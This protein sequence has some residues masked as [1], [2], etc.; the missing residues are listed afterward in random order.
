[1]KRWHGCR[2]HHPVHRNSP[3]KTYLFGRFFAI[4][5]GGSCLPA[6]RS[7]LLGT[8]W[9]VCLRGKNPVRGGSLAGGGTERGY[10]TI[11]LAGLPKGENSCDERP[12][13]SPLIYLVSTGGSRLRHP[14]ESRWLEESQHLLWRG[15]AAFGRNIISVAERLHVRRSVEWVGRG[16]NVQQNALLNMDFQARSRCRCALGR[17]AVAIRTIC[18]EQM[19]ALERSFPRGDE[20]VACTQIKITVASLSII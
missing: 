7:R 16:L 14:R 5:E 13:F 11:C 2:A 4:G 19:V 17:W 15:I 9:G 10:R 20:R 18:G 8:F 12:N 3:W 6:H 1:M